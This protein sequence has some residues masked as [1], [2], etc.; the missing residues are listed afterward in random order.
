MIISVINFSKKKTDFE[1]QGVLRAINRQLL[2]DFEPYWHRT[3]ELRLEGG[4]GR[5]P[6]PEKASE[7]RGD[8]ILYLQDE[9]GDVDALGYHDINLRGI[10]YGFVFLDLCAEMD[11]EWT[12]TLSHEALELVMDPEANL[13]AQGPHPD[14]PSRQVYHWYEMCDAVQDQSYSIDGVSVSNFVLPLYFTEGNEK[15]S[16]ND[17][18]GVLNRGAGVTS[19]GV[20]PGGYVGY[21]DPETGD[22]ESF[23]APEDERA[24]LR[25]AV[26]NKA[27]WA[28][29]GVRHQGEVTSEAVRRVVTGCAAGEPLPGPWF[30]GFDV[31]VRVR[32]GEYPIDHMNAAAEA[33]LGTGWK[34]SWSVYE[35]TVVPNEGLTYD[36]ELVPNSDVAVGTAEAWQK[37]YEL[38]AQPKIADVEPSFIYLSSNLDALEERGS[39]R[40]ASSGRSHDLPQSK[41]PRWCL[42]AMNLTAAWQLSTGAGV[43]VGHPDTGWERHPE[44]EDS[45]HNGP[46]RP[47]LGY[48]FVD[49]DDDPR[50][51]RKDDN[52]LPGGPNH[53]TATASVI[54][55]QRGAQSGNQDEFVVGAA[56]DAEV[57]PLRVANSVTHFSMRRVRK[58]I[59]YSVANGCQVVS[60]S[61]GGP[62]PSRA[63]KKTLRRAA[64]AGVVV[65]AAAGNH[66][67]FRAVVYPARYSDVV[68]VAASNAVDRA[69]AGSSNGD[70]VDI[71][72]PGESV[73]RALITE[74]NGRTRKPSKRSSGTSYATAHIAGVCALW[75][76]HHGFASLRARYGGRLAEAF[77]EVLR[78]TARPGV[79]L[80]EENFVGIVDAEAVLKHPLPTLPT[81]ARRAARARAEDDNLEP[82]R[83]VLP[84]WSDAHL[85]R[86]LESLLAAR[87]PALARRLAAVGSEVAFQLATDQRLLRDFDAECRGM[88]KG[89]KGTR[90]SAIGRDIESVRRRLGKISTSEK[91]RG[92]LR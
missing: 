49:D 28:R 78:V 58:A 72:A 7:M 43:R 30:E 26:K 11:E 81:R 5:K 85:R 46:V 60:M 68:G 69:W 75:I 21:F 54:A 40:R 42:H 51:E 15:G 2:E 29:R 12:V 70:T 64:D 3:G 33:V 62:F 53:G 65:I 16:R 92:A 82:F 24:Q 18:M 74:K 83:A 57:V 73:W 6:K 10:P 56:P 22:H 59:E 1:V 19:F 86:A 48:D 71:T 13:L 45:A 34:Q 41:D 80:E 52:I 87:G 84:H 79:E 20:A 37:S 61:L 88:S 55:S 35:S 39:P 50:A 66:I 25:M 91:L 27:G 32:E 17:F 67:P 44:I 14:D 31:E 76:S 9:V 77:R 89:R 36:Y 63:L 47:D 4:V 8:A 90:A 38:G 23:V